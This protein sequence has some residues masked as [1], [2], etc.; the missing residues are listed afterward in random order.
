[1]TR[2]FNSL[3]LVYCALAMALG[4]LPLCWCTE[5]GLS[6]LTSPCARAAAT[7]SC[8]C[9]V[10]P[11]GEP[12]EHDCCAITIVGF[13]AP[14]PDAFRVERPECMG[15][16]LAPTAPHDDLIYDLARCALPLHGPAPP[17]G[18]SI[19]ALLCRYQT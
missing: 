19:H 5:T 2:R 15:A 7:P 4:G 18:R 11:T 6:L 1:M 3:A 17:P 14:V 9:P 12:Q 8:C 10:E 13:E 16:C